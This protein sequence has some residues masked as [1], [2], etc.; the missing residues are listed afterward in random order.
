MRKRISHKEFIRRCGPGRVGSLTINEACLRIKELMDENA[1]L[2]IEIDSL[3][4]AFCILCQKFREKQGAND[5]AG[6]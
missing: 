3:Q 2:T 1:A 6:R 4:D 5:D